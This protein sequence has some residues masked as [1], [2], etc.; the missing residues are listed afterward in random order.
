MLDKDT[1]IILEENAMERINKIYP[2]SDEKLS[3][4]TNLISEISIRATIITLQEYEKLQIN[5][6]SND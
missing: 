5:K 4:I 2:E 3:G 6:N 1:A